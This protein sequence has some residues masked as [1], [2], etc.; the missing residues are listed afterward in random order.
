M[1][2]SKKDGY[3]DAL[4]LSEGRC[5]KNLMEDQIVIPAIVKSNWIRINEKIVRRTSEP[6]LV[7]AEQILN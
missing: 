1:C 4:I 7:R 3:S 2:R 6:V 5:R